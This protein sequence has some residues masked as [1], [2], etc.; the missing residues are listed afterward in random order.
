MRRAARGGEQGEGLLFPG[1][2]S[3]QPEMAC[4][5]VAER[6][7]SL[8]VPLYGWSPVSRIAPGQVVT[9]GGTVSCRAVLVCVD[10]RLEQLLAELAGTLR[11]ARLQMLAPA[12]LLQE[13]SKRPVYRRYG[14]DHWQQLDTGELVLGGCRDMG[15]EEEWTTEALPSERVQVALERLLVE[16][17]GLA[18]GHELVTHRWAGIVGYTS[19]GLPVIRE[20]RRGVFAAGGYCGTGNVVGRL[21]GRALAELALDGASS[22]ARLLGG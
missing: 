13:V 18:T 7:A 16:T 4:R 20:V 14:Y 19:S 12:P 6:L 1:D 3:L 11:S 17:V 22:T 15:G 5:L 10:G 8:G 9:G 2:V 21:A